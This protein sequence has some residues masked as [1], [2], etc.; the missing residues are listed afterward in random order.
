MRKPGNTTGQQNQWHSA[1][2]FSR[3]AR[4]TTAPGLARPGKHHGSTD[5]ASCL[6]MLS[7]KP[8]DFQIETSKWHMN[9]EGPASDA[10]CKRH[11]LEPRKRQL[12]PASMD[13][14]GMRWNLASGSSRQQT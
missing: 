4:C 13:A 7:S 8:A 5:S 1:A 3:P 9:K 10:G 14:G 12:L 11:A 6:K 2:G